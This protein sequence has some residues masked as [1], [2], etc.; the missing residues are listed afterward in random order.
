[1]PD[2][3]TRIPGTELPQR[4]TDM[5]DGT[6]A[7]G[8]NAGS[9]THLDAATGADADRFV[10]STDMINGAYAVANGGAMPTAGARKVTV[11]HASGDTPDTLGAIT[12]EGLNLAGEAISEEIVPIADDVATG[13]LWFASVTAISG[14]DWALDEVEATNDTIE[15]GCAAGVI[16]VEGDGVLQSV[17][18]NATAAG[19]ITLGDDGGPIAVLKAS[20][21]EGQY[22]FDVKFSGY[23]SISQAA[24]SDATYIHIP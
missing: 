17:S 21:G 20:I 2:Q 6:F 1:M 16:A 15:V 4:V 18:V 5:G 11:T 9:H 13:E 7:V 24:A 12:V 14:A 19:A 3:T 23:L 10:V 22:R 8:L